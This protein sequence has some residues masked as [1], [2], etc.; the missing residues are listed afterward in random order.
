M[1]SQ[2]SD[3][4]KNILIEKGKRVGIDEIIKRNEIV[5]KNLNSQV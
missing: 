5:N 2:K 1:K 3:T 4:E